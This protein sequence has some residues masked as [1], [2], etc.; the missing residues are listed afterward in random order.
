MSFECSNKYQ[1]KVTYENGRKIYLIESETT[2]IKD[3]KKVDTL[4]SITNG[5]KI[6]EVY[7][8]GVLKSRVVNGVAQELPLP[9]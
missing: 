7:E 4:K 5:Q 3:G 6:V 1:K 8:D 9:R 2:V